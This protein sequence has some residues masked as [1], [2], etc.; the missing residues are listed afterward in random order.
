MAKKKPI[1]DEEYDRSCE[2]NDPCDEEDDPTSTGY[3]KQHAELQE[4]F[5]K[6][7]KAMCAGLVERD[8]E[9][10]LVLTALIAQEHPLLVG[11]PGT[12]K[13][14]LLDG[15]TQFMPGATKFSVLF[16]KFTTPEEVFGP[17][18]VQGL[19][20]DQYRRVTTGKLPEAHVAFLDEI[21]KASSAILNT[22][23]RVLN[24]RQFENGDGVFRKV[25]LR[26]C[27]AA[28]NEWPGDQEGGKELG[29]LFDRFLFRK[30]VKPVQTADGLGR[31]LWSDDLGVK[32]GGLKIT[33]R[34][35]G[36]ANFLAGKLKFS[37]DGEEAFLKVVK[38]LRSEGIQPGDR[39]L[40]KAVMA[41]KSS[42]WLKGG[43]GNGVHQVEPE[44]LEI[45]AHV[46]WDDPQEQPEKCAKV[47]AKICNPTGYRVGELLA[48]AN[49][50]VA[51]C[52]P[53]EAVPKLQEVQRSLQGL[54]KNPRAVKAVD[55]V[56]G[57]IKV[58]Y[59]KVINVGG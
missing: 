9:V 53:T 55:V 16:N 20:A 34:E 45:L 29:A 6:V 13:S 39:R 15:L 24:E 56:A 36:V 26:L 44:N 59:N 50:V 38:K 14:M 33:E 10:T 1:T 5:G 27:L 58:A 21:F 51:K 40:R 49:D 12:A 46:L 48:A 22:T 18:S 17:I 31:L 37:A 42:A 52:S 30:K 25:P 19:K 3:S 47:V 23:L 57:M 54:G 4:R 8:E 35:I 11:P 32:T 41:C 43:W 28:S 2:Q 7:R